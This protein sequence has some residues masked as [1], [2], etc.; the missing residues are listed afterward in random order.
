MTYLL[1][2]TLCAI[3]GPGEAD[4]A[5]VSGHFRADRAACE[6]LRRP[7]VEYLDAEARAA[8]MQV[9]YLAAKCEKGRDA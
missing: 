9:I 6:E 5:T 3:I 8:G 7:M 2:T 4:C 1:V